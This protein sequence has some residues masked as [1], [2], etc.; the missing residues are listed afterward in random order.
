[1]TAASATRRLRGWGLVLFAAALAAQSCIPR[2]WAQVSAH[3]A[4]ELIYRA[5]ILPSA[6]PLSGVREPNLPILGAEAACMNCH[7]R[8]GFGDVEGHIKI[9]AVTGKYLFSPRGYESEQRRLPVVDAAHSSRD[10]YTNETLARAIREGVGPDGH[11]LNY[12]MPHYALNEADMAAL[13]EYLKSMT[14]VRSPGVERAALHFATI[15]TS[16]ADPT[17]RR[18]L[19]DVLER[20]FADRSEAA[21][22][23][24]PY[25]QVSHGKISANRRWQLHVWDLT[26]PPEGWDEQL[27]AWLLREPVLAVISGLGGRTWAPIHRFC[28]QAEL[29]CLFPDVDLPVVAEHDFYSVYF[30]RGV[31]LEAGLIARGLTDGKTAPGVGRVVQ[32]FR[33]GDIGEPAANALSA[34]VTGFQVLNRPLKAGNVER[35][36]AAA[37]RDVNRRDALVLWLRPKDLEALARLPAA[38][39]RVF[40]SGLM[41]GLDSAP[42]PPAWRAVTTMAYPMDLPDKRVIRVDFPLGWFRIKRIPVVDER[43]QTDAWLACNFLSET[44]DHMGETVS[45]DYLIDSLEGRLDHVLLTGYYPRLSL[46]PNQRFASKGGYLVRFAEPEG[47]RLVAI[48]DWIAP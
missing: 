47:K 45:R 27:H 30:S 20:F 42:L 40:V 7:R 18:G 39:S 12:L 32:I 46:G 14:P 36:L 3:P 11:K 37:L 29:P 33:S 6:Q 1:M 35:D 10:A 22:A 26:G 38:K 17:Q 21:F 25:G 16:D 41:G 13:I 24:T 44:L 4:G 43:V 23:G 48:S 8:S 15:V 5:G 19:L 34:A 31:L 28:E 9:P 2:S